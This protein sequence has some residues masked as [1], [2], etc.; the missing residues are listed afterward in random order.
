MSDLVPMT[1]G[2]YDAAVALMASRWGL[3]RRDFHSARRNATL[4]R[5]RH[6]FWA[7]LVAAGWSRAAVGK[8]CSRAHSTVTTA[9]QKQPIPAQGD[10]DL[11]RRHFREGPPLERDAQI[12]RLQSRLRSLIQDMRELDAELTAALAERAA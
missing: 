3:Q 6:R 7:V 5:V 11:I 4:V 12:L 10:V 1:A 9:V 2:T 8:A